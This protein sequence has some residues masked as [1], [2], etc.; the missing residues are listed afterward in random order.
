MFDCFQ[1]ES[2]AMRRKP[3]FETETL[4][5]KCHQAAEEL[6]RVIEL[7]LW[8]CAECHMEGMASIEAEGEQVE[9]KPVAAAS[10]EPR[11]ALTA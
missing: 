6:R 1:S 5:E 11:K 9:R 3:D 7:D 2:Y 10:A 4:C 8:V